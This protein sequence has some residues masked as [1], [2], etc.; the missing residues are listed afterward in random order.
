M[1]CGIGCRRG[2]DPT[3][4]WLWCR[5]VATAP[6]R[7]PAR[8]TPYAMG[9]ALEKTKKTPKKQKTK[10]NPG[11]PWWPSDKGSGINTSVTQITATL[12]WVWG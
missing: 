3:L 2:S 11:V 6:I 8:E 5:P 12:P 10:N 9:A 1:S 7:P 4:L